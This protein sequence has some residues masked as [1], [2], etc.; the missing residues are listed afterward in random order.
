L[1]YFFEAQ[2]HQFI[3]QQGKYDRQRKSDDK[4]HQADP[5]GVA[6]DPDEKWICKNPFKPIEPDPF[7]AQDAAAEL[8]I[9]KCNDDTVYRDI[10][11]NDNLNQ[12]QQEEQIK[13]DVLLKLGERSRSL[14]LPVCHLVISFPSMNEAGVHNF[15]KAS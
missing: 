1:H 9:F 10:V 15:A 4:R 11:E 8:E 5:D 7:A 14:Q 13:R 2:A 12:G 3:D 6:K